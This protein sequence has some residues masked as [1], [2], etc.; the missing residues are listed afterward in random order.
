M[1]FAVVSQTEIIGVPN[2]SM[3]PTMWDWFQSKLPMMVR[4]K[5][6]IYQKRR[7]L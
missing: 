5:L 2:A 7:Q 4:L 3:I 6:P 1:I